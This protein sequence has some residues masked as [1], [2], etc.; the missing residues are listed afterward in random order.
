MLVNDALKYDPILFWS[1]F[2]YI[3]S[4]LADG[5]PLPNDVVDMGNGQL[6]FP[7]VTKVSSR[8]QLNDNIY[9]V[10]IFKTKLG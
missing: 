10:I 5:R 2:P 4:I 1:G 6:L 8:T 9:S 7:Y 3:L